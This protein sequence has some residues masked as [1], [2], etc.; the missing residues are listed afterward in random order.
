MHL[1]IR[2]KFIAILI[3]ASILPLSIA[4]VAAQF[5]SYRHYRT[6]QGQL[7]ETIAQHLANSLSL[8][9]NKQIE[10]LDEWLVLSD[11]PSLLGRVGKQS[12]SPEAIRALEEKW[13][14][15]APESPELRQILENPLAE[16][17]RDFQLINPL[18]AEL[19]VTDR[20][21]ALLASTNKTSDYWQ[22]DEEWWKRSAAMPSRSAYVE[23]I[24]YDRS[25][26]VY[27][28]DVAFPI[29]DPNKAGGPL[30]GVVKGVVSASP[31]LASLKPVMAEDRAV[32]E[33]VLGNGE[34]LVR[35]FGK[36]IVTIHG[37][38]T[39]Q[40]IER[41]KGKPSGWILTSLEGGAADLVGYASLELMVA[42]TEN[43]SATRQSGISPM[44]VIVYNSAASALEPVRRQMFTVGGAGALLVLGFVWIG[45]YIAEKKILVPLDK[46][47]AVVQRI[48]KSAKVEDFSAGQAELAEW[49]HPVLKQLATIQTKDELQDLAT[50]FDF[51]AR[52][53]LTY[54]ENLEA[55]IAAKTAETQRDLDMAREFQEALM[56]TSYPPIPSSPVDNGNL[57]L[58]FHH[59]YRPASTVG[60]DF[61]DVIKLSDH[62]VGV[63]IADVMGH[64]A[65][66]AL[67]TAILR[68]LIQDFALG[69]PGPAKFLEVINHHFHEIVRANTELIFVSAFYLVLD[70]R[71]AGA[72]YAAAGHPSPFFADRSRRKVAPLIENIRNNPAL[73]L[74]GTSTYEEH[75]KDIIPGDLFML[76]TDGAFEAEDSAGE[77]FGLERLREVVLQNLDL[78]AQELNEAVLTEIGEFLGT[79]PLPDDICL[80]TVEVESTK[81]AVSAVAES[82]A[83]TD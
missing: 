55:E 71:T 50:E 20:D 5:L 76:F 79:D 62:S 23:G 58:R 82:V 38:V 48:G 65:R 45:Y 59:V 3:I 46:L 72:R 70:T 60:G 44:Y 49:K 14:E 81:T 68:T 24:H 43:G 41:L 8:S 83:V 33:V 39:A 26:S 7:Y 30:L 12:K 51:M 66:S 28:I 4:L 27:S 16:R 54:H 29:R 67:V 19:F 74:F 78:P 34:V 32:R 17:L 11:V 2:G 61:F 15:L 42:N 31:L 21:G 64:G 1:R 63:F 73:G 56:P 13:P 10:D 47:R 6:S 80:V 40:A 25:A 22:A 18:F 35:L 53:V 52:R 9:A 69:A 77:E 57:A 75:A 37:K 36:E